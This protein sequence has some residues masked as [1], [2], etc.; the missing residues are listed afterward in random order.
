MV[1][2]QINASATLHIYVRLHLMNS[3]FLARLYTSVTCVLVFMLYNWRL[4]FP[5]EEMCCSFAQY[6]FQ[7]KASF[8][9]SSLLLQE[10]Y[11]CDGLFRI[12]IFFLCTPLYN[13]LPCQELRHV[14]TD[15]LQLL[16]WAKTLTHFVVT[17]AEYIT[18]KRDCPYMLMPKV[19]GFLMP[20][21][22]F[23]SVW[24]LFEKEELKY[25]IS[26]MHKFAAQ[27][28]IGNYWL[29]CYVMLFPKCI[30]NSKF[31]FAKPHL[32]VLISSEFDI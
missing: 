23:S 28:N 20:V 29:Q 12:R 3:K 17:V 5:S 9:P 6:K 14:V 19:Y 11:L 13:P 4:S 18:A 15:I 1:C 32:G 26:R 16:P 30:L 21:L 24:A 22:H 8:T 2:H 25:K 7:C 10:V 27:I 31:L